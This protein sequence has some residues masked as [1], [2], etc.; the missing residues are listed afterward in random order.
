MLQQS[1]SS[2]GLSPL[3]SS[4]T[5]AEKGDGGARPGC[6][7]PQNSVAFDSPWELGLLLGGELRGKELENG[8]QIPKIIVR[9]SLLPDGE[10]PP[11]RVEPFLERTMC[12]PRT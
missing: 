7:H 10:A 12:G 6:Q 3:G 9:G 11:G 2:Q 8:F 4:S 1:A 5:P